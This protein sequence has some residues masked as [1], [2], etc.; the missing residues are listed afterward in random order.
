MCASVYLSTAQSLATQVQVSIIPAHK[1]MIEIG[2]FKAFKTRD[3]IEGSLPS[4]ILA[5]SA[6]GCKNPQRLLLNLSCPQITDS[7][8]LSWQKCSL[9]Y[10]TLFSLSPF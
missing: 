8:S 6:C 4:I 7:L 9:N 5:L 10:T 1:D 2:E 3:L